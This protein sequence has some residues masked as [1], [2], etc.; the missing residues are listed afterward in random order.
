MTRE[1]RDQERIDALMRFEEHMKLPWYERATSEELRQHHRD[2]AE[3][4]RLVC[5]D[6]K[7][8]TPDF[9]VGGHMRRFIEEINIEIDVEDQQL[10]QAIHALAGKYGDSALAQAILP[11]VGHEPEINKLKILEAHNGQVQRPH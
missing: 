4:R 7:A 1:E 11:L 10:A 9:R 2:M 6:E 8:H 3:L 5:R